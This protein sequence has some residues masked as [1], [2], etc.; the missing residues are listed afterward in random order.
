MSA[1]RTGITALPKSILELLPLLGRELAVL[2]AACTDFRCLR[3][4]PSE[5]FQDK[6]LYT[7]MRSS[8]SN[9]EAWNKVLSLYKLNNVKE[10][11]LAW[12]AEA[13]FHVEL[14]LILLPRLSKLTLDVEDLS[15]VDL[16]L[17]YK[18]ILLN[19]PSL[20]CLVLCGWFGLRRSEDVPVS[21]S[22]RELDIQNTQLVDWS[23]LGFLESD[24]THLLGWFQK[25]S[26]EIAI[27]SVHLDHV[28]SVKDCIELQELRIFT[29]NPV[30]AELPALTHCL[31]ILIKSVPKVSIQAYIHELSELRFFRKLCSTCSKSWPS[32]LEQE[33]E[34]FLHVDIE[35][36]NWK[37][38]IDDNVLDLEDS[39]IGDDID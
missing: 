16:T 22:L 20:A 11:E 25:S 14:L 28:Y 38:W 26:P 30:A 1:A 29:K 4:W 31:E 27:L 37:M 3:I 5:V 39:Y 15:P 10:M 34:G 8:R 23:T 2:H 36:G 18:S 19:L 9:A 17:I 24:I 32:E 35:L 21:L 33:K 13:G 12:R 6:V 7:A